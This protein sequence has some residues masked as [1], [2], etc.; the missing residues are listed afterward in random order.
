MMQAY[1]KEPIKVI[2]I[3][4]Q[5]LQDP[6]DLDNSNV[7]LMIFRSQKRTKRMTT[8][9]AKMPKAKKISFAQPQILLV[10]MFRDLQVQF[11]P[12]EFGVG[13]CYKLNTSCSVPQFQKLIN[14]YTYNASRG[15]GIKYFKDDTKA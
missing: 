14:P 11:C 13:S 1:F 9:S 15:F 3:Q 4:S 6:E 5:S 8:F 7:V 12:G 10:R 2:D